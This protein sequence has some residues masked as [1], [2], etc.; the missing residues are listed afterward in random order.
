MDRSLAAF[1]QLPVFDEP[2]VRALCKLGLGRSEFWLALD[3]N[4]GPDEQIARMLVAMGGDQEDRDAVLRQ[5]ELV[6]L[7][8]SLVHQSRDKIMGEIATDLG[9]GEGS[10]VRPASRVDPPSRLGLPDPAI[11]LVKKPKMIPASEEVTSLKSE[12]QSEKIRWAARLKAIAMRAGDHALISKPLP[13]QQISAEEQAEIRSMVFSSGAF[14]TIRVNVL[15][16]EKMEKWASSVGIS[17]YPLT[18]AVFARYCLHLQNSGCGPSVLPALKYAVKW[19]CKR[20]VME[21]PSVDSPAIGAIIE[22]V[23]QDRGKELKEAIAVPLPAVAALEYLVNALIIEEKIPAAI[24]VWWTLILIYASLRWDDGRHVAPTSLAITED[25]LMGLVWQTK[26]ERKRR[27]T[28]FA[29]PRCS[30]SGIAWLDEGWKIFQPFVGDRDFFIWDLVSETEFDIAPVSYPKSIPWLRYFLSCAI[31]VA[32][33]DGVITEGHADEAR[34]STTEITWHSMRATLLSA[35]VNSQVDDKIIG[36]QANWK[37]P[38]QLVLKY[39]RQ[40]KELSIRMVK[41]LAARIR[42]E[43][44]PDRTKFEVEDDDDVVE[45]SPCEYVVKSSLPPRALVAS[46]LRYHIKQALINP[47]HTICGR[48][49]LDD[50]VSFG[51]IAPGMVCQHCQSKL[52]AANS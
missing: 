44:V 32:Q 1:L 29:V 15:V 13:G 24:F 3:D 49:S 43:W 2:F 38:S 8:F 14:R 6:P 30:L 9:F 48:L 18:E 51:S 35:A 37:D 4:E 5:I 20:L 21:P 45:P 27:G 47:T 31:D 50:V 25:A 40:R 12:E 16:W 33:T 52:Q 10:A 46:D 42:S 7:L 34:S 11:P 41:D 23:Y 39:A 36:L 22:K 26:V 19:V 17:V 28:R